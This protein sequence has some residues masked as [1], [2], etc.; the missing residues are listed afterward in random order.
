MLFVP[1]GKTEAIGAN[2]YFLLIAGTGLLLDAGADPEEEGPDSLPDFAAIRQRS[3]WYVDH[4]V[5][6]HAHHDHIGALPALIQY[7]P[8]VFVHV[9]RATRDLAEV[10]L[11]APARLQQRRLRE[12]SSIHDP[13]FSEDEL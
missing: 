12:G 8:H 13:L 1:L 11:P 2:C 4:A 10:V 9:T 3:D 5:I 6:T 7:F